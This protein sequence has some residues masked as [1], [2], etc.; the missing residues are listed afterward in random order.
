MKKVISS[1]LTIALCVGVVPSTLTY[2]AAPNEISIS[3]SKLTQ[4]KQNISFL[5]GNPGDK[6][7]VYTYES[8]GNT[9][10]VEENANSDLS[11]VNSVIYLENSDAKFVEYATQ[12]T[13]VDLKNALVKV[14]TN[15]NGSINTDIQPLSVIAPN[16]F[17]IHDRSGG[18]KPFDSF[19]GGPVSSWNYDTWRNGSTRFQRYTVTA[20]VATLTGIV[21]LA[22]PELTV[23]SG[24]VGALAAQIVSDQIPLLYYKQRYAEKKS[25]VATSVIV[26][27]KWDTI[28]YTDA[29]RTSE[30]YRTAAAKYLKGYVEN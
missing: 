11:K 6:H 27:S 15:E 17:D 7:L 1:V 25:L 26:A 13:E 21:T 22:Q 10:K 24:T 30:I 14:T 28:F 9:Y 12:N 4:E 19:M 16:N 29:G 5:E 20:V 18:I 23:I 3:V 8:E 2:A